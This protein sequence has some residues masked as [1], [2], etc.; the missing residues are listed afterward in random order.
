MWF[1][2]IGFSQDRLLKCLISVMDIDGIETR[3][4]LRYMQKMKYSDSK[5]LGI[6]HRVFVHAGSLSIQG[7]Y[8]TIGLR[9]YRSGS[10]K[11]VLI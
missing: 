6:L 4:A 1:R 10:Q 9:V 5:M 7:P 2:F 11:G 3:V 8:R